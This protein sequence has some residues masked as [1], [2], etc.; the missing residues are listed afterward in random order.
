MQMTALQKILQ[1]NIDYS[2]PEEGQP[3]EEVFTVEEISVL[4]LMNNKL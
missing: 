3:I 1:M 4:E 2:D